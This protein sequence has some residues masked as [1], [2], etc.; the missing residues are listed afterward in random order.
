MTDDYVQQETKKVTHY[1]KYHVLEQQ[2]YW[3]PHTRDIVLGRLEYSYTTNY[4]TLAEVELLKRVC[5]HL[6]HDKNE[7]ILYFIIRHIDSTLSSQIGENQ[8]QEGIPSAKDLIRHGLELLNSATKRYNSMR[9]IESNAD[10][11]L[12]VLEELAKGN[13]NEWDIRLQQA[14]FKKLLSLTVDAYY[15][16]PV[17]WSAIGYGGPAYPRGYVRAGLGQLDPW[18]AQTE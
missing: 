3:D 12:A 10:A 18:E 5:A 13:I 7:E 9:F 4:L 16:H 8:R 2:D 15:S 1:P 11:Q 17:V 6:I 14:F